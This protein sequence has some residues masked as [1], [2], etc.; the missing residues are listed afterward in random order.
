MSNVFAAIILGGTSLR[1]GRRPLPGRMRRRGA[2]LRP[3]RTVADGMALLFAVA[4]HL[5][6]PDRRGVDGP[7]VQSSKN[8][9][10]ID[11]SAQGGRRIAAA[12]IVSIPETIQRV[13]AI[14]RRGGA[15]ESAP[16]ERTRGVQGLG[17]WRFD[18]LVV[19]GWTVVKCSALDWMRIGRA[20]PS[21][22]ERYPGALVGVFR[23]WRQGSAQVTTPARPWAREVSF[24]EDA[25]WRG[26]EPR[27]SQRRPG[28]CGRRA[29]LHPAFEGLDD[30]HAPAAARTGREL[31][32]R[33]FGLNGFW[34]RRRYG[35]Q[36]ADAGDVGLACRARE[37]SVMPDAVEAGLPSKA[38][39][40]TTSSM[41][42]RKR[43]D[44]RHERA[45]VAATNI[46]PVPVNLGRS[47]APLPGAP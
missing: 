1:G 32:G 36:F 30:A 14:V 12:E 11:S 22:H 6:D 20:F 44:R 47:S 37:Q 25:A 26:N 35:Q 7:P 43:R 33:L 4:G 45:D 41:R 17:L 31:S 23:R 15:P 34:R 9:R 40:G 28:C 3:K 24:A 18:V 27:R 13:S 39:T 19:P 42:A 5:A 38:A 2:G 8:I 16:E 21:D 10:V 29:R 46:N